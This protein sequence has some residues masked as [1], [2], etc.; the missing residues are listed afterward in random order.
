MDH[1]IV[2]VSNSNLGVK[3]RHKV[4]THLCF[5]IKS[6]CNCALISNYWVGFLSSNRCGPYFQLVQVVANQRKCKWCHLLAVTLQPIELYF[7]GKIVPVF[8]TV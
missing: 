2:L 5:A 7:G 3:Q 8:S 6:L 1:S 4:K